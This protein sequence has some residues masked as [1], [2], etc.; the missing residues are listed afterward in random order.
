MWSVFAWAAVYMFVLT[1]NVIASIRN[2]TQKRISPPCMRDTRHWSSNPGGITS[3]LSIV[4]ISFSNMPS[5][6]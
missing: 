5:T 2:R 3:T 1:L 4:C 6:Y